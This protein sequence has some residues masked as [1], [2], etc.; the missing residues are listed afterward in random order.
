MEPKDTLLRYERMQAIRDKVEKEYKAK[1]GYRGLNWAYTDEDRR[2]L[3]W[4]MEQ[5]VQEAQAEISFKAGESKEAARIQG[6]LAGC[7][8]KQHR[9]GDVSI[10]IDKDTFKEIFGEA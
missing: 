6:C 1:K 3:K 8:W 2:T 10:R 9:N 5:A 7:P 4:K